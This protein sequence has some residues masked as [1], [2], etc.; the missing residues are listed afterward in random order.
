MSIIR[1]LIRR[2]E[3][4]SRYREDFSNIVFFFFFF[5]VSIRR[6]L[7]Y[8]SARSYRLLITIC[9]AI[10]SICI[11][12]YY[13]FFFLLLLASSLFF[14][15]WNLIEFFRVSSVRSAPPSP[16]TPNHRII[17]YSRRFLREKTD[18]LILFWHSGVFEYARVQ[19]SRITVFSRLPSK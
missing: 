14:L 15:L 9:R 18:C 7:N 13:L 4:Y 11:F 10:R 3:W 2:R 16:F 5:C 19:R 1:Q 8:L 12:S 6:T 17:P